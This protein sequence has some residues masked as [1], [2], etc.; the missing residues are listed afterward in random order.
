ME[1]Q[2]TTSQQES[3]SHITLKSILGGD[4][5]AVQFSEATGEFAHSDC[6]PYHPVYRQPLFKPTGAD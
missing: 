5:L 6:S 1:Q 3:D 2:N 4:I